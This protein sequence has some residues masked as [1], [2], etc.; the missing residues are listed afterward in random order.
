VNA[1]QRLLNRFQR[2]QSFKEWASAQKIT[3]ASAPITKRSGQGLTFEKGLVGKKRLSFENLRNS[4]SIYSLS[5]S[6]MNFCRRK[7]VMSESVEE[8]KALKFANRPILFLMLVAASPFFLMSFFI[9]P[10]GQVAFHGKN[11]TVLKALA[12]YLL[13][14]GCSLVSVFCEQPMGVANSIARQADLR[15]LPIPLA[16]MKESEIK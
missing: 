10:A 16:V 9:P 5:H 3:L 7:S 8:G 15:L 11:P 2:F 4:E 14:P 12:A 13:F 6:L 1:K